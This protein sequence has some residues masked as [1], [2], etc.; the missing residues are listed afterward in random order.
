VL[1]IRSFGAA[2]CDTDHCLKVAK[3]REKL[4]VNEQRWNRFYMERMNLKKLNEIKR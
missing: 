3:F 2:D 1:V 4:A